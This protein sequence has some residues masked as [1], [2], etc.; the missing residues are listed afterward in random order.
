MTTSRIAIGVAGGLVLLLAL[1][2]APIP[3]HDD[4]DQRFPVAPGG[5]LEVDLDFGEG[6]RP[7]PGSLEV[8]SHDAEEVRVVTATTGWGGWGVQLRAEEAPRGVRVLG[9]VV[10]AASWLFGGPNVQ[11]RV[12]VPREYGLDLRTS[13]G[14]IRVEE[15]TGPVRARTRGAEVD[16]EGIRGPVFVRVRD[17]AVN[18]A[19]VEGDVELKTTDGPV[20]ASWVKGQLEARTGDGRIEVRHVDGECQLR[21]E[22]GAIEVADAAGRVE[23]RTERGRVVASFVARPSGSLESARGDVEVRLPAQSRLV[24]DARA[25][26]GQVELA[27]LSL[28]GERSDEHVTGRLNGDG[29]LLRLYA[30]RGGVRVSAR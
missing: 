17:G 6:L 27:G 20:E 30:S 4:L 11:V 14:P 25:R 1:A 2:V 7:D 22:S 24:L 10:G 21:S 13:A 18:V 28:D 12:W 9:R 16:L 3:G 5:R 29:P 23:A 19:E 15:I 26:E 8:T